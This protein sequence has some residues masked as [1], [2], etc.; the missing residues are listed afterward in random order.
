PSEARHGQC[1]RPYLLERL[2]QVLALCRRST[3]TLECFCVAGL[4]QHLRELQQLAVFC[5]P[6]AE[7]AA[8][9]AVELDLLE[10]HLRGEA[11]PEIHLQEVLASC[12][13]IFTGNADATE[14]AADA[15][16]SSGLV[17]KSE[18]LR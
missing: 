13:G 16:A 3:W 14:G 8:L 18:L 1:L 9:K 15:P 7:R 5:A 4:H 11:P 2:E 12:L 6:A 17:Q 10:M